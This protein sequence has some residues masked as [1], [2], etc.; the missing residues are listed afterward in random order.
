[1]VERKLVA[2]KL[3][4]LLAMNLYYKER[5]QLKI[6]LTQFGPALPLTPDPHVML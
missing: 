1:M 2:M 3:K 6:F 4:T 5:K